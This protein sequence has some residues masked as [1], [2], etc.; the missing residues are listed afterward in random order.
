MITDL[1]KLWQEAFGD[2]ESFIDGFFTTGYCPERSMTIEEDGMPIAALYWFDGHTNGKKMAYIYAVA[3]AKAQRGKGLC[4]TLMEDTHSHL[5]NLGYA[6]TI[7]VPG[8]KGLFAMYEK[9]GYHQTGKQ[10]VIK[11]NMTI[12]DYEKD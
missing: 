5:K 11:E 8:E 3:T 1:K 10:T 7:L 4:K 6:A 2:P 9:M 12:V